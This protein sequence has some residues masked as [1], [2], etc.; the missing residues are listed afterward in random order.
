[1]KLANCPCCSGKSYKEC[2]QKYHKGTLP[3]NALVLMRSRYAAYALGI[4]SYIMQT[5][6]PK[7]PHFVEDTDK[8]LRDVRLFSNQVTFEK[9]E[10]RS[11]Q[12][13]EIDSYVTFTAHL[14]KDGVDLTFSEKSRFL[15]E[16]NRWLYV[17][18]EISKGRSS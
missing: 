12:L 11:T 9:L 6:H 17:D 8:W 13:D 5:T 4:A 3:E 18:G 2:C 14:S 16:G 15:K 1:M 7:S 10:I